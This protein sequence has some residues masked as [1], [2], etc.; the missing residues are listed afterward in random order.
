[1]FSILKH[2]AVS[3]GHNRTNNRYSPSL[4]FGDASECLWCYGGISPFFVPVMKQN[5][6]DSNDRYGQAN[7]RTCWYAVAFR[8]WQNVVTRASYSGAVRVTNSRNKLRRGIGERQRRCFIMKWTEIITNTYCSQLCLRVLYYGTYR[9]LLHVSAHMG[10]LQASCIKNAKR[11][12]Y[13]IL[14]DPLSLHTNIS[15]I[16]EMWK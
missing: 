14:S 15:K 13:V 5:S 1:M 4:V 12:L 9:I 11:L 8:H 6:V 7:Y 3:Y 2:I 16:I 10:H